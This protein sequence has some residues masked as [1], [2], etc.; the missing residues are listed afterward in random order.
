MPL[1]LRSI[2]GPSTT[3]PSLS[4]R[5][6]PARSGSVSRQQS[7][8]ARQVRCIAGS[9]LLAEALEVLILELVPVVRAPARRGAL[10]R[11]VEDALL[12]LLVAVA[13]AL[14]LLVL[15]LLG[16]GLLLLGLAALLVLGLELGQH[17]LERLQ[18]GGQEVLR[19]L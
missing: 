19:L 6:S 5:M 18:V 11:L 9:V 8:A 3:R 7:R 1:S 2:A 17:A 10:E 12:V 15:L 4:T 16:R 14:E 13:P